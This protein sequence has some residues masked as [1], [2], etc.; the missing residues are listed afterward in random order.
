MRTP[1]K[2]LVIQSGT[3]TVNSIQEKRLIGKSR[4]NTSGIKSRNLSSVLKDS[5]FKSTLEAGE[6]VSLKGYSVPTIKCKR[7][8]EELHENCL[9]YLLWCRAATFQ[10]HIVSLP[11]FLCISLT[12]LYF[13]R[14]TV[15][16]HSL[17]VTC[18]F[19]C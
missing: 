19:I 16:Y 12:V 1:H 8:Y 17:S 14:P 6:G 2:L 7:R 3:F 18:H 5:V 11:V 10:C 4:T 15:P 13:M 9:A